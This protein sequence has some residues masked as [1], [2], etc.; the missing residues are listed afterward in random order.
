MCISFLRHCQYKDLV[1]S[2]DGV[3][4]IKGPVPSSGYVKMENRLVCGSF[5]DYNAANVAC[6]ELGFGPAKEV[7]AQKRYGNLN[8]D[9]LY[10]QTFP[11]CDGSEKSLDECEMILYDDLCEFPA[12][13]VCSRVTTQDGLKL[14]DGEPICQDGFTD[15]EANALCKE[16]GFKNGTVSNKNHSKAQKGWWLSCSIG[17]MDGCTAQVS[18]L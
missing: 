13:V 16:E 7:F 3:S 12:G 5:W 9:E 18:N 14:L 10:L 6:H 1:F 4:L 11:V 2:S 15:I 8:Q 17:N